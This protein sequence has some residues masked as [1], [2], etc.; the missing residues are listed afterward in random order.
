MSEFLRTLRSF[1]VGSVSREQLLA[2]VD[3]QLADNVTDP[4][5]MLAW[6]DE[7]HQHAGLSYE[8]REQIARKIH[9]SLGVAA[10]QANH[11]AS[12][13][14]TEFFTDGGAP[15]PPAAVPRSVLSHPSTSLRRRVLKQRFQLL[16]LLGEG[17]MGRVYKAI[18]LR[19]I[20]GGS[21]DVFVAVKLLATSFQ[22]YPRSLALLQREALKLQRL[23]HP[24]IVRVLDCDRDGEC[25]FMTME[26][27][28]GRSLK[29]KLSSADGSGLD[30]HEAMHILNCIAAALSFAHRNGIV[31]GDLKPG[32]VIVTDSGEVRVIDFGIAGAMAR[33]GGTAAT[34]DAVEI[35]GIGG[36]TPSYSSP[37]MLER[38]PSDPRDD[39]YALSCIAYELLTGVHPF[40][41]R[42]ATDARDAG[43]KLVRR[44][45]L[46]RPQFRAL[47]NGMQFDRA[48]RTASVEQFMR[49]LR[50][51]RARAGTRAGV[52]ALLA[53]LAAPCRL[54][55]LSMADRANAR[56]TRA[57]SSVPGLRDLSSDESHWTGQLRAR[58]SATCRGPAASRDAQRRLCARRAG[59]D[60]GSVQSVR[61]RDGTQH[62][63]LRNL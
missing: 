15:V 58:L 32:N 3:R 43:M 23:S 7:A 18:D 51:E 13:D 54:R 10:S 28:P 61:R 52:V 21:D 1:D 40:D 25:V 48:K 24:N 17:G 35:S 12:A 22:G 55:D 31:H 57:R 49:D 39:V 6:L 20:E 56:R 60:S 34:R 62:V 27:L 14:A 2:E 45:P 47:L 29:Q 53:V 30:W 44:R 41:R 59:G 16:E 63:G 36:V 50:G 5:T 26:Y 37:E 9:G 33:A 42:A 38:G 19:R 46:S 11:S 4:V 8:L